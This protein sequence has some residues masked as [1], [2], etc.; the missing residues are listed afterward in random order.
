MTVVDGSNILACPRCGAAVVCEEREKHECGT[1]MLDGNIL[2]LKDKKNGK[3]KKCPLPPSVAERALA[4][5]KRDGMAVPPE[6]ATRLRHHE[7][8][9]VYKDAH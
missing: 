3:W 9:P 6:P 7:D 1:L 4:R 5:L 2:W 8:W